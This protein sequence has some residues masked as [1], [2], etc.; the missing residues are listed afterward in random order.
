MDNLKLPAYPS[1]VRYE[2]GIRVDNQ[3]GNGGLMQEVGFTKLELASLMI[4]QGYAS[5]PGG[6]WGDEPEEAIAFQSIRLAKAV[7]E[8]AN[9]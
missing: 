1:P 9:K 4:A 6:E 2:N 8:E 3:I 7:L 5:N